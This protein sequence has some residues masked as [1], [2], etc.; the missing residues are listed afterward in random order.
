MDKRILM[1]TSLMAIESGC[2][3]SEF[4]SIVDTGEEIRDISSH[5]PIDLYSEDANIAISFPNPTEKEMFVMSTYTPI[6]D[7]LKVDL[8]F[9]SSD[10]E[11]SFPN[12]NLSLNSGSAFPNFNVLVNLCESSSF[13][14]DCNK[15]ITGSNI[16]NLR[17][18][19]NN[20]G[21]LP[22][23]YDFFDLSYKN[24]GMKFSYGP[25]NQP[26]FVYETHEFEGIGSFIDARPTVSSIN[27]DFGYSFDPSKNWI[28]NGNSLEWALL[29]YDINNLYYGSLLGDVN[30][31]PFDEISSVLS[32][33]DFTVQ[34]K[35]RVLSDY[36]PFDSML[37]F[38]I[39][40]AVLNFEGIPDYYI[41]NGSSFDGGVDFSLHTFELYPYFNM[42]VDFVSER[43]LYNPFVGLCVSDPFCRPKFTSMI[44]SLVNNWNTIGEIGVIGL[45]DTQFNDDNYGSERY[46]TNRLILQD[47][48]DELRQIVEILNSL[49]KGENLFMYDQR[50]LEKE[51]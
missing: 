10:T 44:E 40:G 7:W 6:R 19:F 46:Y 16:F 30:V 43:F 27:R 3:N 17:Y 32:S 42:D 12:S 15:D 41:W 48:P 4:G 47:R 38:A 51:I 23:Y 2:Q 33:C 45:Y 18:G 37:K 26:S 14:A 21:L 39:I 28:A 1:V 34:D 50:C 31:V 13:Y 9:S 25:V 24:S 20:D 35:L 22:F 5:C 49:P 8:T 36:F 11:C 29:S